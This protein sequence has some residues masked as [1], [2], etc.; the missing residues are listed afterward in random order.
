MQTK[1]TLRMEDAVIRKAK[2]LAR[3][4]GKSVSRIF[5]DYILSEGS[6]SQVEEYGELTTS[7]IGVLS[8]EEAGDDL[9]SYYDHLESKHR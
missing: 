2:S 8:G 7:M 9:D 3:K 5:S 4:R 6:E 1:L